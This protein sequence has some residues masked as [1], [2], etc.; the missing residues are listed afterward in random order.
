VLFVYDAVAPWTVYRCDNQAE[1]LE[2]L[3]LSADVVQLDEIDLMAAVQR[4]DVFILNRI[5]YTNRVGSLIDAVQRADKSVVF[6]ADDLLFEPDLYRNFAFLDDATESDRESWRRRLDRY[7][8]TLEAC[9]AAIVST[10]PLAEHARRHVD[11]VGVVYNAV[12]SD[13]LA[14]AEEVPAPQSNDSREV[15]VGYLSGTPSHNRD[16]LEAADAVLWALKAYPE[17]RVLVVGQLDLGRR[18]DSFRARITRIP[19]QPFTELSKVVAQIDINL[20]P[21]E[22]DNPFTECKSCVKYLEAGLVGVPTIASA[23]PDFVR[24][25]ESGRNGFLAAETSDWQ[26]ALRDLIESAERRR[27]IGALARQD[28]RAQ[29]STRASAPLLVEALEDVRHQAATVDVAREG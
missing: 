20:A 26:S 24:V 5:D 23:R 4:Y 6:A 1:Q 3:G 10:E 8:A 12:S 29:Q 19:R 18:F 28:V 9:G 27:S 17:V 16:F 7:R 15:V 13:M 21:L 14:R 22:R 25:I 2:Y 11:R